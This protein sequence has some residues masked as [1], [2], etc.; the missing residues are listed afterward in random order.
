[1]T[2]HKTNHFNSKFYLVLGPAQKVSPLLQKP[3]WFSLTRTPSLSLVWSA[4]GASHWVICLE[5]G[6]RV[7]FTGQ[8][9]CA[10]MPLRQG[11]LMTFWA[12]SLSGIYCISLSTFHPPAHMV[13]A[14]REYSGK[15]FLRSGNRIAYSRES[16]F[17][18][19]PPNL[20]LT[21]LLLYTSCESWLQPV[22]LHH[23][24]FEYT[25]TLNESSW[26]MTIHL[27]RDSL[28]ITFSKKTCQI[29]SIMPSSTTES[30]SFRASIRAC[31][32]FFCGAALHS[33]TIV[34]ILLCSSMPF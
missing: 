10:N 19:L 25:I 7:T 6:S 31:V 28:T 9:Q 32:Y 2:L 27:F 24:P 11:G 30:H 20:Y 12:V 4:S 34:G 8:G 5:E 16:H 23:Q 21:L 13:H 3:N 26:E 29:L 33:V 22:L 17:F 18:V 1:M 15:P 14:S